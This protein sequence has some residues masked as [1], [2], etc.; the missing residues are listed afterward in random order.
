MSYVAEK[1]SWEH[2]L[3]EKWAV[4]YH[5]RPL[6]KQREWRWHSVLDNIQAKF[7]AWALNRTNEIL[8]TQEDNCSWKEKV[9]I[10]HQYVCI[11]ASKGWLICI[12]LFRLLRSGSRSMG[13]ARRSWR[14]PRKRAVSSAQSSSRWRTPTRRLWTIWRPWKGKTR[15]S[16]VRQMFMRLFFYNGL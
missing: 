7:S 16:S 13:R 10:R 9:L 3:L 8:D 6:H 15:T 5:N 11:H 4:L 2:T 14:G 12:Y 1:S